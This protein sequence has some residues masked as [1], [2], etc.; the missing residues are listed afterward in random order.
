MK[1]I[2]LTVTIT[3]FSI[4]VFSQNVGI[5]TNT[6]SSSAKLEVASTNSGFLPPRMTYA[7]RNAIMNPAA[8]L[9]VWCTDCGSTGELSI[10]NGTEWKIANISNSSV[11]VTIP[12]APTNLTAELQFGPLYTLLN[13]EDVSTAELGYIIERK[14]GSGV[15]ANLVQLGANVTAYNDSLVAQ[16]TSYSYRVY[17]YNA[18]GNSDQYSNVVSIITPT[19]PT[20][21]TTSLSS[22]S[23]TS[24]M[25]GGNIIS[26]GGSTITARGV[27]WSTSANPTIALSTK[28]VD[29]IGTGSFTSSITGLTLNI[30]Y[31][32]RAYA[33]N[34]VGTTYGNDITFITTNLPNLTIGT[35][36]WTT[37]NLSVA[38]YRNGDTIPKVTD[39][40]EWWNLTT[41]AW[42]WYNNDSATYASTYGRLYNWYAVNDP[43]GLAPLGWHVPTNSEWDKMTKHL[44]ASVDT[45]VSGLV[46]TTIGTQLK[47]T[48]GW[49]SGGNGTNSSGFTGLPGGYRYDGGTFG[50]IGSYGQWWSSTEDAT[51]VAWYR[52]LY[53]YRASVARFTIGKLGGFS[54]RLVRD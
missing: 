22:I 48:S 53:N 42:C 36:I 13:W 43:R 19:V 5:G 45:I 12:L 47:K 40:N 3:L 6:P 30:T 35:Q 14:T 33:T 4:V 18:A 16:N 29:G 25:S 39:N 32:V 37:Q 49:N 34:S 2:L 24:A 28:T 38:K 46:G 41:G 26:D 11:P 10:F 52:L 23:T 20:I 21:P 7:Q 9:I 8:G 54:V 15:F 1:K 51:T 44:D 27:C 31:H 50:G 17:A